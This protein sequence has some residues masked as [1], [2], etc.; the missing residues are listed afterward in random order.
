M[1]STWPSCPRSC[2]GS[3]RRL[4]AFCGTGRRGV[5][6]GPGAQRK[7][8][9][10]TW[11]DA[12]REGWLGVGLISLPRARPPLGSE[13]LWLFLQPRGAGVAPSCW[14]GVGSQDSSPCVQLAPAPCLPVS[15]SFQRFLPMTPSGAAAAPSHWGIV[16]VSSLLAQ[17]EIYPSPPLLSP[18]RRAPFH[19]LSC[20]PGGE[21]SHSEA[22]N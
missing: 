2:P 14:P 6:G 20:D 16:G 19:V 3:V 4:L 17:E 22:W 15:L 18:Y 1:G 11:R 10:W 8:G 13:S 5:S 7:L 9:V 21:G 12:G